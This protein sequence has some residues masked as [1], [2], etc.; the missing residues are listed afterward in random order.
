MT[1]LRKEAWSPSH[2]NNVDISN[3]AWEVGKAVSEVR[4]V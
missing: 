1:F 3:T 4:Y 2:V